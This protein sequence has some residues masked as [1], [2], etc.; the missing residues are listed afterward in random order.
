MDLPSWAEPSA[1]SPGSSP[2]DLGGQP[3]RRSPRAQNDPGLPGA[4]T[5]DIP[6]GGGGGMALLAA[7]GG[8]YAVRR[9]SNEDDPGG[10][11]DD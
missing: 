5:Q 9:L 2:G 11:S 7:A 6:V 1:P 8:A 10:A 4:P 3:D